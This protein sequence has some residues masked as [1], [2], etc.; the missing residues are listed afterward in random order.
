MPKGETSL[1][2]MKCFVG[3]SLSRVDEMSTCDSKYYHCG[4][5]QQ[6]VT[7]N[8]EASTIDK[9]DHYLMSRTVYRIIESWA[10]KNPGLLD[11]GSINHNQVGPYGTR[12]GLVFACITNI[13]AI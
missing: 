10:S 12:K 5:G 4:R 7:T 3:S 6:Q 1:I 13:L 11:F 9:K 8:L 2:H